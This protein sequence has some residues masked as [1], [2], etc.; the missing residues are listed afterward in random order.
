MPGVGFHSAKEICYM[1]TQL[2][3]VHKERFTHTAI[4]RVRFEEWSLLKQEKEWVEHSRKRE[5]YAQRLWGRESRVCW[6]NGEKARVA[7]MKSAN[8]KVVPLEYNKGLKPFFL[9]YPFC[10]CNFQ[11]GLIMVYSLHNRWKLMSFSD[12]QTRKLLTACRKLLLIPFLWNEAQFYC[13]KMFFR[14]VTMGFGSV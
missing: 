13:L 11:F 2:I 1:E 10:H 8:N 9:N 7:G 12:T 5:Q 6:R 3:S 14:T 4:F